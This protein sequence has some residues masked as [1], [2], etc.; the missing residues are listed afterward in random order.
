ME[1]AGGLTRADL[2]FLFC[3][4]PFSE[5]DALPEFGHLFQLPMLQFS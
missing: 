2:L 4:Q 1:I 3:E 5:F